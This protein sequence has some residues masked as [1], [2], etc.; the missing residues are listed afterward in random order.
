MANTTLPCPYLLIPIIVFLSLIY[1]LSSKSRPVYLIDFSCY[2]PPAHLRVSIA[3]FIEHF[4]IC[5]HVSRD[6]IDFLT[7]VIERSGIGP[8]TCLPL[9]VHHIPPY[10]SLSHTKLEVETVLFTVVKALIEKHKL[11]PKDIDILVS[12]CSIFCPTPSITSMLINEFGFREDVKSTSL[13][14]MGCSAGLVAVGLARDLLRAAG[15]DAR[16]L[17][18]SMEAVTSSGYP[19]NVKSMLLANV[20]FRM[21]GAAILLSNRRGDRARAK[22][23]LKHLIR[24]HMGSDDESYGSVFQKTDDAGETGVSLSK[25][26]LRVAGNALRANITELGPRC[27][28]VSEQ[29]IYAWLVFSSKI[30]KYCSNNNDDGDKR[31]VYAPDFKKAFEH[32]CIHA[33]GRAVIDAVEGR[34]R[35]KDEDVEA[36]RMTLYRFGNTSSSSVWYE[37]SYLEA[38]DR[39]KRGD[40]VWQIA[41]GSGFKCNSAVWECVSKLE[42]DSRNVWLDEID[43]YPVKIPDIADH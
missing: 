36:S 6:G 39:V 40:R 20:L 19:G 27:L 35:L 9:A 29:L 32:F 8:Q 38:K 41:F 14:G 31:E 30:R 11:N 18:L 10:N 24:T 42:P 15:K 43:S 12:N 1:F 3:T 26:L 17:V 28:P 2:K 5:S 25:S 13:S 23:R 16:A 22:Y 21:G 34:L 7:K 33:G 4:N 37:L